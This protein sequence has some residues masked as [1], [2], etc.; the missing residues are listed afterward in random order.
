[1]S[2]Q[3]QRLGWL[4]LGSMGLAMA[5]NV[6][7]HLAKNGLPALHYY[8]RTLARGEPLAEIGGV[9][10][11]G[12]KDLVDSC[13]VIFI[14][15]SDD[16]ALETVIQL[17]ISTCDINDKIFVDTTTVHPNT[18]STVA[19]EIRHAHASYIAAPVFGSTPVAQAGQLLMSIAGPD[20]AIETVLPFLEGVIARK[21]IRMHNQA[22][23]ALLLKATSNFITAGLHYLIAEAH[24]LAE[25]AG[26][27]SDALETLIHE[28]FGQYAYSVS[29]R[30]TQGSYYPA[31][32]ER[33]ISALELGMKDV[34]IGLSIAKDCDKGMRLEVGELVMRH[35]NQAMKYGEEQGRPL[36]SS[37]VFGA[38][39][40]NAGLGFETQEVEDRESE[41]EDLAR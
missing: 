11:N 33:P 10:C 12:I 28:N 19:D 23:S 35:M 34:G 38:V 13:D 5:Q 29:Q 18:T 6:Q 27:P 17:L 1:M 32:G 31:Q 9:P 8:N 22:S 24:V 26:L 14:S 39:R 41:A 4:G 30:M 25:K 40:L 37:S 36:D 20:S 21:V 16:K 7:K 3:P 15:L 2:S